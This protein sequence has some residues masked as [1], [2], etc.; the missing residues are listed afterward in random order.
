MVLVCSPDAKGAIEAKNLGGFHCTLV[1]RPFT[2]PKTY[3]F[4]IYSIIAMGNKQKWPF[5]GT[6]GVPSGSDVNGWLK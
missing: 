5:K 2:T 6:C 1:T 4:C 3:H